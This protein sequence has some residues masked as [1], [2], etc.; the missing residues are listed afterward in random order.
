MLSGNALRFKTLSTIIQRRSVA[1]TL[2]FF[3][4]L[5]G[6]QL[7]VKDRKHRNYPNWVDRL[8]G[9]EKGRSSLPLVVERIL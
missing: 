5:L 1:M 3:F 9:M 6:D 4:A 2:I 8:E 7:A